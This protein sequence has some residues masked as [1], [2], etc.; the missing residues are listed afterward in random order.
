MKRT[1]TATGEA[2]LPNF[3]KED[4][5]EETLKELDRSNLTPEQRA[6][7]EMTIAGNMTEKVAMEEEWKEREKKVVAK[8]IQLGILTDEQIADINDVSVNFIKRVRAELNEESR[9]DR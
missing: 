1:D 9:S 4:W 7:L 5:L 2:K 8:S 6:A 3:M